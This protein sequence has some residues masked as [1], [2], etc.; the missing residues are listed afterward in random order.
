MAHRKF[1]VSQL[2]IILILCALSLTMLVP[3]LNIFAMS[4]SDPKLVNELQGYDILSK[5]FS[6][7]NYMVILS[8]DIVW[9][10]VYNSLFITVIGVAF[11]IL[12][13]SVRLMF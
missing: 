11:N 12:L 4:F 5:G 6:T 10:S 7:I 13:T 2:I 9:R 3:I 8:N 1:S